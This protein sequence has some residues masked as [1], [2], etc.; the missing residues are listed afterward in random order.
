MMHSRF[1]SWLYKAHCFPYSTMY[2]YWLFVILGD[3]PG[4][5]LLKHFRKIQYKQTGSTNTC[6]ASLSFPPCWF[7]GDIYTLQVAVQKMDCPIRWIHVHVNLYVHWIGFP[8]IYL[9]PVVQTLDS[10]IHRINHYPADKY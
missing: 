3:N 1:V 5:N 9:A 2:L 10:V 6:I 8:N 7:D 4:Q